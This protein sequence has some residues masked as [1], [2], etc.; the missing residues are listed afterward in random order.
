MDIIFIDDLRATG[1]SDYKTSQALK[2]R[3][4]VVAKEQDEELERVYQYRNDNNSNVLE[5]QWLGNEFDTIPESTVLVSRL[6]DNEKRR[7]DLADDE[8]RQF[9]SMCGPVLMCADTF[10]TP[11]DA[12]PSPRASN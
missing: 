8:V 5:Q 10:G 4:Q 6:H 9:H 1:R 3:I 2:Q 11:L 12:T 7:G